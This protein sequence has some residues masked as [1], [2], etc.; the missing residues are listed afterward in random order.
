MRNKPVRYHWKHS[1]SPPNQVVSINKLFDNIKCINIL[2]NRSQLAIHFWIVWTNARGMLKWHSNNRWPLTRQISALVNSIRCNTPV[3]I[4]SLANKGWL[5]K[6][7]RYLWTWLWRVVKNL[8]R[9]S[10][11]KNLPS[12]SINLLGS[13]CRKRFLKWRREVSKSNSKCL[14]KD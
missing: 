3:K 10:S 7:L 6:A 2:Q 4:V 5:V 1:R 13:N 9:M 8:C 14:V 12:R 11:S